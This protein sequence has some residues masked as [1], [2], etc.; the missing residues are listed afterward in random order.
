MSDRIKLLDAVALRVAVPQENL[1]IGEVG[2]VVEELAEDVFLVEF[3]DE[4]G[5]TYAMPALRLE[6]L[7]HYEAQEL[8]IDEELRLQGGVGR[9]LS[10]ADLR[11]YDL[12][13][14]DLRQAN[15]Q[16]ADLQGTCLFRANLAGAN[17]ERA[18]LRRANLGETN[19]SGADFEGADLQGANLSRANAYAAMFCR[20][21]LQEANLNGILRRELVTTSR[22]SV[23]FS[24]PNFRQA[25]L[26]R[27]SLIEA[28]LSHSEV[29]NARF[30]ANPGISEEMQ[31]DL[32]SRGALYI[33]TR[34]SKP[35][36]GKEANSCG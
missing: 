18:N 17:F 34:D 7:T 24:P 25:N 11:G 27:A 19:L 30:G 15:F 35:A 14:A 29:R 13:G 10:E 16:S 2:T 31:Q 23:V 6:Q 22:G 12:T 8:Q 1:T 3:C 32:M 36:V 28:D 4:R 33:E 21:N 9:D 26:L 5:Q 20:A